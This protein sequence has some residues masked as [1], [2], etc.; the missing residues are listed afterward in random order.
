MIISLEVFTGGGEGRVLRFSALIFTVWRSRVDFDRKTRKS[1]DDI[2]RC[3]DESKNRRRENVGRF[4]SF[5]EFDC[6]KLL[7][8][9][10]Q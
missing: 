8:I 7:L 3:H 10:S 9:G 2:D 6:S 1:A 4:V 5:R